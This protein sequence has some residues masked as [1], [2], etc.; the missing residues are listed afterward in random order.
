[1]PAG[2]CPRSAQGTRLRARHTDT[3]RIGV[4][5]GR[6]PV[7]DGGPHVLAQ[8]RDVIEVVQVQDL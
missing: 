6:L 4:T 7:G 8:E 3:S 1:M 2:E 5:S